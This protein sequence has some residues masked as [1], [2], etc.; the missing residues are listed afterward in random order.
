MRR[1]LEEVMSD[2]ERKRIPALRGVPK[3]KLMK[4][5][6]FV[7][8]VIARVETRDIN[9]GNDLAYPASVVAT[10]RLGVK[11]GV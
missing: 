5:V 6:R 2:V 10:E 8:G 9:A 4:E 3:K 7:D 1:R 11:I